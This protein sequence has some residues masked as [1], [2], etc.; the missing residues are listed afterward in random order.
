[1]IEYIKVDR[2]YQITV[3]LYARSTAASKQ[4]KEIIGFETFCL[5]TGMEKNGTLTLY[6]KILLFTFI[7]DI[8][9]SVTGRLKKT[10]ED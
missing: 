10:R 8:W 6:Y 4:G 5:L 9:D 7:W 2:I 3:Y 1:M